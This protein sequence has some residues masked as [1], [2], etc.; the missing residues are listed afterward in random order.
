MER[1]KQMLKLFVAL[2]IAIL[3]LSIGSVVLGYSIYTSPNTIQPIGNTGVTTVQL[4]AG[5]LLS[6]AQ[7]IGIA[8]AVI[9]L[10]VLAIKYITASASDKAEIKKSAVGY[11]VGAVLL[12]AGSGI[13]A[14]IQGFAENWG[15]LA[16]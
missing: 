10:V 16:Y 3:V 6:I 2:I 9:I 4:I 14:I 7:A 1:T 11:I 12:F 5:N 8:V 15:Y 13:L